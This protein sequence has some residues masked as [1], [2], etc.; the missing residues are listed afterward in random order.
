M[1]KK[2]KIGR[3]TIPDIK[4]HYKATSIKTVLYW[5]KNRHIDQRNRIENPEI[6]PCLCCQLIFDKGGRNIKGIKVVSSTNGIGRPGQLQPKK[7]KL[8]HQVTP[9]TKINSRWT[10]DL[11]ISCNNI[12]VLHKNIGKISDIPH[13]NIFTNMFLDQVT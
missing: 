7:M 5:H 6:N 4:L 8:G 12:R 2:N 1:K 9:Q 10:K 13:S 3:I 11:N